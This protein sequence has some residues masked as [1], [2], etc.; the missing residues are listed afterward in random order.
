MSDRQAFPQQVHENPEIAARFGDLHPPFDA[1]AAITEANR[2]L[3]CFDAPCT[4]A[5]PTHIDVPRF[6]KKIA[7]G[8][9]SGS[10][11]HHPRRQHPRRK[12]RPCLPGRRALRRRLRDASL[13][14]AAHRRSRRLQRFAMDAFHQSGAPLPFEPGADTGTLRRADRRRPS[15]TRLRRRTSP[16]RHPRPNLRRT[17]AAR[18]PQHLRRRRVQAPARREPARDRHALAT[19]RRVP[20]GDH[21]RRCQARRT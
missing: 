7:T 13:Q 19:R 3:F 21:N 14:Q 2:C 10:A 8:N 9:L 17:P 20:H 18:R 4:T 15:L 16:P 1:Q 6:I 11:T 12:L 5:C